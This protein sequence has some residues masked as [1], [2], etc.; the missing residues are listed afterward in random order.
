MAQA[1]PSFSLPRRWLA[2]ARDAVASI[3]IPARCRLCDAL[4]NHSSR[5]PICEDCLGGFGLV[6]EKICAVCGLP[7][8][9]AAQIE[10]KALQCSACRLETYSFERAR[11]YALYEGH[12]IRAVLMLKFERIDPLAK[13][14]AE[15]L[16]E[17]YSRNREILEADVV[18]PVPL[19][20]DREK[21]R[22]HNQA[23]LLSK[24]L[25]KALKLPPSRRFAGA[26][27]SATSE[28][29]VDAA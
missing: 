8:P 25:A 4:L 22:G 17:I 2:Q 1:T 11:S 7:M 15:R 28:A 9:D 3:V 12:V 29:C 23:E 14:F 6:P 10:G 16:A 27:T 24:P 20:R 26:K 5:I 13:W 21:E 19:H 18:V